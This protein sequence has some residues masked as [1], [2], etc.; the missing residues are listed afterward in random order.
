MLRCEAPEGS[1]NHLPGASL[2]LVSC[3]PK[4]F[5]FPASILRLLSFAFHLPNAFTSSCKRKDAQFNNSTTGST[6]L[7]SK[8]GSRTRVWACFQGNAAIEAVHNFC[9]IATSYGISDADCVP[10][11]VVR[12]RVLKVGSLEMLRQFWVLHCHAMPRVRG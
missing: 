5:A 6:T 1:Q 7:E 4:I 8:A 2:E 12:D 10:H 3:A 9:C 11:L